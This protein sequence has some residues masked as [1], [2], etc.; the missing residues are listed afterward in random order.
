MTAI[1]KQFYTSTMGVYSRV[2]IR[3][4][5]LEHS[6]LIEMPVHIIHICGKISNWGSIN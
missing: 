4:N 2:Q 5:L 3:I 1:H 6:K